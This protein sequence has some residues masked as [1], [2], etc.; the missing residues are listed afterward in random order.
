MDMKDVLEEFSAASVV[1]HHMVRLHRL[2]LHGEF[3]DSA[4]AICFVSSGKGH[5][6]RHKVPCQC[7]WSCREGI[8]SSGTGC[9]T[10]TT[11]MELWHWQREHLQHVQQEPAVQNWRHI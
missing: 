1:E 10:Q 2:G 7:E 5:R 9:M 6:Y 4:S 8:V 3:H 11:Y